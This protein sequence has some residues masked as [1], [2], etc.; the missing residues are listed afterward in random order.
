MDLQE[1]GWEAWTGLIWPRIGQVA[2]AGECG[3]EPSGST[4]CREFLD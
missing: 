1:V 3:Y 2:G 4:K